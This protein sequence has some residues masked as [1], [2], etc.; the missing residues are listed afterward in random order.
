MTMD[1]E[2]LDAVLATMPEPTLSAAVQRRTLVLARANL[3]ASTASMQSPLLV[4]VAAAAVPGALLSADLVFLADAC[5]KMGR[6]F[7]SG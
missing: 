3:P 7:G 2:T 1:D 6:G 4:R 5:A